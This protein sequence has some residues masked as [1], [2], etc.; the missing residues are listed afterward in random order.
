VFILFIIG[1]GVCRNW[2]QK[3]RVG[4]SPTTPTIQKVLLKICDR[5]ITDP[6]YL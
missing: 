6:L 4:S 5:L 1:R 3:G 2:E